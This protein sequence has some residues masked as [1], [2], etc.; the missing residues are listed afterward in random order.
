MIPAYISDCRE[1]ALKKQKAM[2][3]IGKKKY[4]PTVK[5]SLYGHIIEM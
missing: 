3:F 1:N 5:Q 4:M 2:N